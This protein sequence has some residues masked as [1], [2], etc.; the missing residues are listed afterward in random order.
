MKHREI[1]DDRGE[2][3]PY[4]A[5]QHMGSSNNDCFLRIVSKSNLPPRRSGN[6]LRNTGVFPPAQGGMC[7]HHRMNRRSG[8]IRALKG[9]ELHSVEQGQPPHVVA[10][11]HH[12]HREMS[13]GLT[14]GADHLATH[15]LNPC[16]HV[17]YSSA[18]LGDSTMPPL[19]ALRQRLVLLALP[20]NLAAVPLAL[21][22]RFSRSGRIAPLRIDIPT[23]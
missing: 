19:R 21:P 8:S 14:E 1:R 16:E 7:P 15:L 11:R 18:R 9:H 13:T 23:R 12:R 2:E 5:M 20:L 6:V 22:P 3:S 17:R 10:G 4:S